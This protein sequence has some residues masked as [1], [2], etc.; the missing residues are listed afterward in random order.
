MNVDFLE[1]TRVTFRAQKKGA[2]T[3]IAQLD[4]AQLFTR[5]GAG[6]NSVASLMKHV[7]GNLNSRWTDFLTTDGDK[8]DRNRDGEFEPEEAGDAAPQIRAAWDRGWA[9]LE[10]SL[11]RLED[12]DL[13]KTITI[14]GQPLSVPLAIQR[15][16][17]HT[18]QHVG[19]I[20]M[21]A[22]II[23]GPQWETMSKPAPGDRH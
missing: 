16:L 15:S 10:A 2:D 22:K 5:P 8:P 9:A 4:D 7:G 17:A 1:A 11:S 6:S 18:A 23:L 14:R 13:D 20:I 19:Q 21:L 12:A 3:A